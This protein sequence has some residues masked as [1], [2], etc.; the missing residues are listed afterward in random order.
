MSA[1]LNS[2]TVA[3]GSSGVLNLVLPA[4]EVC[5]WQLSEAFFVF[6]TEMIDVP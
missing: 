6:L 4:S 2:T 3:T 1:I 5:A